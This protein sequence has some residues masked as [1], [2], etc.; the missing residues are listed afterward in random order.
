MRKVL[1]LLLGVVVATVFAILLCA[2]PL[3]IE[4][5]EWK[6]WDWRFIQRGTERGLDD[7][8]FLD[9]DDNSL[10][11]LG[12]FPIPRNHYVAALRH[13][14]EAK[15]VIIDVFFAERD[16]PRLAPEA[17]ELLLSGKPLPAA[18]IPKPADEGIAKEAARCRAVFF[19]LWLPGIY[20]GK[21]G[22]YRAA[23]DRNAIADKIV[24]KLYQSADLFRTW[25]EAPFT[26]RSL[27]AEALGIKAEAIDDHTIQ[28]VNWS[29]DRNLRSDVESYLASLN[30]PRSKEEL[31]RAFLNGE[32]EADSQF[33]AR[34]KR[35]GRAIP[36]Q[37]LDSFVE[38]EWCR[39][40]AE[41]L[42]GTI[43]GKPSKAGLAD[44]ALRF[45]EVK[46]PRELS[47]KFEEALRE[48]AARHDAIHLLPPLT[49]KL[50][51]PDV[52]EDDSF[53]EDQIECSKYL[54]FS[55]PSTAVNV[56]VSGDEGEF[57]LDVAAKPEDREAGR[58]KRV[59]RAPLGT[60]ISLS[61]PEPVKAVQV[62]VRRK[63]W[64]ADLPTSFAVKPPVLEIAEQSARLSFAQITPDRDGV[65]RSYP[66]LMAR[67]E[68]LHPVGERFTIFPS[69]GLAAACMASG[70]SLDRIRVQPGLI[71]VDDLRIPV[72]EQ[73]RMIIN[74]RGG[75]RKSFKNYSFGKLI[76]EPAKVVPELKDKIVLIGLTATG[77]HDFNPV[78]F[79]A[80]YPMVGSHANVI[81]TILTK[82]IPSRA[83]RHWELVAV[84]VVALLV[85]ACAGYLGRG[86]TLVGAGMVIVLYLGLA[87][88][89]F[90]RCTWLQV[91]YSTGTAV[92]T[93]I[94][95]LL[96]RYVTE[97]RQK[98]MIRNQFQHYLAPQLVEE[99]AQHPEKLRL[100]GERKEITI[101]FSDLAG[102]SSISE[103]NAPE[104]VVALLNDY[105][106]RMSEIIIQEGGLIDKYE[107][108]L[109]MAEFGAPIEQPDHA[110]RCCTAAVRY[111]Q[112]LSRF[113]ETIAP[114][115]FKLRARIG[116][117][118]G[119]VLVGNM[120]SRHMFDYTAIGNDVDLASRLEGANKFFD[121]SIMISERTR[122]LAGPSI[123]VR[124]LDLI[125]VAGKTN[126]IKVYELVGLRESS[127]A[128]E[129]EFAARFTEGIGLYRSRHWKEALDVFEW[130]KSVR[131]SDV[132]TELYIGRCRQFM[133]QPPPP[134]WAGV[135]EILKK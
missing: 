25:V 67:L 14:R 9:I 116:I 120:G 87:Y 77:T 61:L 96:Y 75:W 90:L 10:D 54:V 113:N 17:L 98:R 4:E 70:R 23:A 121:T 56:T 118:S 19:P 100:G 112:E 110:L 58:L 135:T 37:V 2:R 55:R 35:G 82:Q 126:P 95:V 13:L 74:W 32:I 109:I 107:G 51:A 115:G 34:V 123:L 89:M 117:N 125:R 52:V 8:V 131:S 3:F 21:E 133:A 50:T 72:D 81:H 79:E 129:I 63:E 78:P 132:A 62:S 18:M 93:V 29:L 40:S 39:I 12:E 66:M 127:P 97:E 71:E 114:R 86:W 91:V 16:K 46:E 128:E 31:Y 119:V 111:Q 73:S 60:A 64:L 105:L 76:T 85:A 68:P 45:S 47:R 99:L 49:L 41:A 122:E 38:S 26:A 88:C 7:I 15:M 30:D 28:L 20:E 106:S 80:R 36:E 124:E 57:A 27:L 1:P 53:G 92:I 104:V 94:V 134:D 43:T 101:F 83:A 33:F 130:C 84:L 69:V 6:S 22:L 5:L 44:E 48:A 59:R 102:F 65:L 11:V 42:G 103:K 108:D 24:D